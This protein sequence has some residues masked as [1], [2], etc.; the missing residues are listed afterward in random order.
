[1]GASENCGVCGD[2]LAMPEPRPH[3][4]GGKYGGGVIVQTYPKNFLIWI[5]A[6]LTANHLGYYYIDVCNLDKYQKESKECFAENGPLMF[7]HGSTKF[8]VGSESGWLNTT[9]IAPTNFTCRRC[10]LRWTYVAG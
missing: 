9:A 8:E 1:M 5:G 3:E 2:S 6:K 10:V 7:V 4:L